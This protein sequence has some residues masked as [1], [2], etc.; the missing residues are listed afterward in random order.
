MDDVGAY[1]NILARDR[2]TWEHIA[3]AFALA[4]PYGVARN[5]E[6]QQLKE[7][8]CLS[9]LRSLITTYAVLHAPN[10]L[11]ALLSSIETCSQTLPRD[12]VDDNASSVKQR[13]ESSDDWSLPG[14]NIKSTVTTASG[15]FFGIGDALG[16]LV[17]SFT[18]LQFEQG[19]REVYAKSAFSDSRELLA[20]H[21]SS[22]S[23]Q[24]WLAG[25]NHKTRSI[26]KFDFNTSFGILN[27]FGKVKEWQFWRDWYQGFLDGKPLDWELQ[28]RV[29]LIDDA[30][31][32]AG[33]EDVAIEIE[34]I[35]AE[36]LAEKL[37][38]AE[39]IKVNP[40]T[41]KFRAIAIP[42]ENPT[43]LSAF[44]SQIEDALEDC[45]GGHNGLA[46][47]S[48]TVKKLNRVLTKYKDDPQNT[49]LTLT[50]VAGSLRSQLHETRELP[51][52]EDNLALLN[53]VEEG[54]R[55]IRANHPEVAKN[56]EQL[57][58]QA[59]HA[60]TPKDKDLLQQALPV[61]A[62]ISDPELTDDFATD[63]PELINDAFLPLPDGAPPLP[64]ADATTRVFSRVSKMAL[65]VQKGKD[66]TQQG[67][68]AFDSDLSKSVRLAG[69]AISV[70][71]GVTRL[72]YAVVQVGLRVLGV[73]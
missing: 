60:L 5:G 47:R 51:D 18:K 45:L 6:P 42:V 57:A 41:G 25:S 19:S 64:G 43:T 15:V 21:S 30:I 72:L 33:P 46:E 22:K 36:M 49:E 71:G 27:Y 70:T 68:Q 7:R 38:M 62:E 13:H 31:W 8:T 54:V 11:G 61:L 65:L 12:L 17:A 56:R 67:A 10:A 53:A 1:D 58:Q 48:G 28:R 35:Q 63:I 23:F 26:S 40:D 9:L 34:R 50:R 3:F 14:V 37:P 59:L 29:A 73:L 2:L 4:G 44:L 52:N 32:E 16:S 66:L 20:G 69:L 39:R 24:G 55:G